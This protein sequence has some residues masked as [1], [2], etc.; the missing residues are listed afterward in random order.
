M[1]SLRARLILSHLL[2]TLV[3]IPLIG[4]ALVYLLE[5]QVLLANI[6]DELLGQ[7]MLVAE[8]ANDRAGI[9]QDPAKAGAFVDRMSPRLTARVMLL[10]AHGYL[11]ASSDPADAA[12]PS[13][14]LE[15]PGMADALAGQTNTRVVYGKVLYA[16]VADV[17]V[18]VKGPNQQVVGV[19]RL[20]HQLAGIFQRFLRLRYLILAV[21]VAG[22][23]LGTVVGWLLAL[24]LERPLK[25]VT[26]AVYGVASGERSTQLTE[27][28]PSE[29][30][31]L[32][33]AVNTMVE[34]LHAFEQA[35]R[36]L[37]ANLVHELGRP[38]G[39]LRSA[40]QALL[41]GADKDEALRQE[42]MVGM[43]A[44]FGRLQ[45]LLDDLAH[46]HDQVL[47]TLEMNLQPVSLTGWLHDV[48]IPWREAAQNKE[49]KWEVDIPAELPTLKMDPDRLAQALSNLLSNAVKYTPAGGN[50]RV[51]AGVEDPR[52]WIRVSDTGPGIDPE[53]QTR[54]FAP[55]FRGRSTGRFP[56]GMG[57]GLS[58]AR[59]L[60]TAHG[61][62]LEVESTPG[63]GSHF[64][65]QLPLPLDEKD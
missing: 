63:Q 6:S 59:D 14:A 36:Q 60:V 45:R 39:A 31:L 17:L 12:N 30:R 21:L 10:D 5:T 37:L 32:L 25:Q 1:N 15:L 16:E 22:L 57:L 26:Q 61:G 20:T 44:E 58:I 47:G 38:L 51:E 53:D 33:H 2:P 65:I 27:R 42:L 3:I 11:L 34:R 4:V 46:L 50:L 64:T 56:Q 35:R 19:V 7:A 49:L 43:D 40:I 55:F 52:I 62:T 24:N 13:Q 29:I 9:W 54:I 18:P 48:L 23:V 8:M 28:G 41:S